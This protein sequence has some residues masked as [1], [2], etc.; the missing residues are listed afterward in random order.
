MQSQMRTQ[1]I[2]LEALKDKM[3]R[4]TVEES[5]RREQEFK[6]DIG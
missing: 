3:K 4:E 2:A 5:E 1:Q 6:Q